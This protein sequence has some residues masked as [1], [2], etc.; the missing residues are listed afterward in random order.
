VARSTGNLV[1]GSQ[2]R[3]WKTDVEWSNAHMNRLKPNAALKAAE[4]M[5]AQKRI[6]ALGPGWSLQKP[7]REWR[8]YVIGEP[9]NWNGKCGP[10]CIAC[11][12]IAVVHAELD[13]IERV[14]SA[15]HR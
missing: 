9:D 4:E 2:G 11:S 8:Q 12:S 14:V 5:R 1:C 10:H 7:S 3:R 6:E 15:R 13:E